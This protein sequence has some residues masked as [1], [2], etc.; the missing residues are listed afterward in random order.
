MSDTELDISIFDDAPPEDYGLPD[1]VTPVVPA[2]PPPLPEPP[3][4]TEE[5]AAPPAEE[6]PAVEGCPEGETGTEGPEGPGEAPAAETEATEPPAP[7]TAPTPPEPPAPAVST[8]AAR[9]QS[10]IDQIRRCLAQSQLQ[11]SA[12][13]A[14]QVGDL[15]YGSF[16]VEV[17]R[18]LAIVRKYEEGLEPNLATV[19]RDLAE[20]SALVVRLS[21]VTGLTEAVDAE[22]PDRQN[23]IEAEYYSEI[24]RI[25][26]VE[27]LGISIEDAKQ[28]SRV[29]AAKWSSSR[30]KEQ[31]VSRALKKLHFSVGG[32]IEL[33]ERLFIHRKTEGA[34]SDRA[35]V[36]AHRMAPPEPRVTAPPPPAAYVPPPAPA[37]VP[38]P[39][40]QTYQPPVRSPDIQEI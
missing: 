17:G 1:D 10:R 28:L 20:L 27:D 25:S 31:S 34:H 14:L 23:A 30:V 7:T 19:E 37:H 2:A 18:I 5:P 22:W 24:K 12:R 33:I 15:E 13:K 21:E 6:A 39:P 8:P 29:E 16:S 36:G 40:A 35:E 38:P 11:V 4:T 26:D 3:A 9:R 32:F